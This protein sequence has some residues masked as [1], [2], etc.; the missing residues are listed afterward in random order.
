MSDKALR[1]SDPRRHDAARTMHD[2]GFSFGGGK[3]GLNLGTMG[4]FARHAGYYDV[5]RYSGPKP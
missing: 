1:R 2:A 4:A 3:N 5:K